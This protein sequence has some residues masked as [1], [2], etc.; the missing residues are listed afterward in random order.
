MQRNGGA[1]P[2]QNPTAAPFFSSSFFNH[3]SNNNHTSSSSNP[4]VASAPSETRESREARNKLQKDRD[5]RPSF[6]RKASFGSPSKRIASSSAGNNAGDGG[7]R[8]QGINLIVTDNSAPPALPDFALQ[9]AAAAKLSR[10][11]E[12]VQSPASVDSFSKMLSRTAPTPANGYSQLAPPVQLT[13]SMTQP[14]EASMVHQHIQEIANKRIST[15]DYLRKAHEGRV[16]WFNTLL[17]DKPDLQRLPYFASPKL[18]RRATNYLLLGLSLPAVIDLNSSTPLDFLRSLNTLLT[19]FD[20]FQSLHSDNNPSSSSLSRTRLPQMFKRATGGGVGKGR[21]SSSATEGL[22]YPLEQTADSNSNAD[23]GYEYAQPQGSV[24]NF[25]HSEAN[26]DLLPGEEYTHLLTPSLPFDPDF[27]ETFATLCDVLI[28]CYTRLLS[29]VTSPRECTALVGELF[30]K[31]D[32]KV[33]KILVQGVVK[34]F[35]DGTRSGIKGEV[36]NVGKV[37]LGGLM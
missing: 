14:S 16:Y 17:F 9:L 35:E 19:E 22:S 24:I 29:L 26:M 7:G 33:R 13:G 20:A 12:A 4:T 2:A 11:T 32:G 25:S 36:A 3:N 18:A 5:R 30:A 10:E 8:P 27:F 34:E 31:A 37:V 6:S 21:R 28:D 1:T 15:L 23:G